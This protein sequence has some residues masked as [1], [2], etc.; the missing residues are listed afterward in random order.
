MAGPVRLSNLQGD[1]IRTTPGPVAAVTPLGLASPASARDW[2]VDA[3]DFSFVP[4]TTT[5]D[6]GDSVTWN[7][8]VAGHTSTSVDGQ[9][10]RWNSASS[11]TNPAGTTFSHRFT[12][13]GSYRYICIPHQD[14]MTGVIEVRGGS[15]ASLIDD[16]TTKRRGRRVRVS[17]Q[18]TKSATVTY[19]LRGPSRRTIK[20]GRLNTGRHGI[21]VRRLKRGRYRGALTATDESGHLTKRTNSFRIR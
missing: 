20:R 16:V 3:V 14:F 13:P 21:T 17:F 9:A 19:R 5:V 11:A 18:L 7:F 15:V 12:E 6:V 4:S 10:E 1:A 2:T 8:T